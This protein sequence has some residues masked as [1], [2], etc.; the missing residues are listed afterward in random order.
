LAQAILAQAIL[1]EVVGGS[2]CHVTAIISD[3]PAGTATG[4]PAVALDE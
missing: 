2:G 4:L 3:K 1:A